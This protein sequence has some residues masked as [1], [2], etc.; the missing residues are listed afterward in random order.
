MHI[1]R[2]TISDVGQLQKIALPTFSDTFSG[3]NSKENMEKYIAERF[4][5]ESLKTEL[6]NK[7]S[8]FYF[9]EID[10]KVVGYLKINFGNAQTELKDDSAVEI[11][12]IYV[13]KAFQGK[14]VGQL[15]FEKAIRV[16]NERSARY[17]W[18]GVWEKNKSALAFYRKNGFVEF[19]SHIF[20]LGDEE[21]IDLMMKLELSALS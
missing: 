9:A 1:R 7:N 21:Q 4:S 15:L 13:I 3:V 6:N 2:I 12:R 11:E 17:I 10:N 20:R 8:E 18:L 19:D 5:I 14:K 16:A